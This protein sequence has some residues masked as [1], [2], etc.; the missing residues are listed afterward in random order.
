MKLTYLLILKMLTET[1]LITIF[2]ANWSIFYSVHLLL[3]KKSQNLLVIGGFRN[4]FSLSM[5]AFCK[6]VQ[7][8]NR[9]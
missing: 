1:L 2:L 6:H 4:E 7:G 9:R 8:Q 3:P 5:V